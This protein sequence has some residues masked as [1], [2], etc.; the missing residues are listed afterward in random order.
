MI[1]AIVWLLPMC[2]QLRKC[3]AGDIISTVTYDWKSMGS[4]WNS[5][6]QFS[7]NSIKSIYQIEE[8]GNLKKLWDSF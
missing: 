6:S 5:L 4:G 7:E 8:G 1:A 3:A 2:T